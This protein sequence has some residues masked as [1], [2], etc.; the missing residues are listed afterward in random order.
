MNATVE[1]RLGFEAAHRLP[2][3]GG[4]CVNLHGHSW[5]ATITLDGRISPDS[6][7]LGDLDL[8]E[9]KAALRG[10]VD[11]HLDHACLLGVDDP[12]VK[13]LD[14]E[15]CRVHLFGESDGY[16]PD[17]PWP[18]TEAVAVLLHRMAR[19]I[20]APLSPAAD[21]V[22]VRITEAPSIAASYP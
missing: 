17:L 18:T 12:L 13:A 19:A 21:V 3:I 5:T 1:V 6:A 11:T 2:A 20:L 10:W 8:G 15:G 16:T 14:G 9:A 7:L 22:R 4:K